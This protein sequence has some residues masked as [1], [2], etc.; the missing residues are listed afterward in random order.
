MQVIAP[1]KLLAL[2][3]FINIVL[4]IFAINMHGMPAVYALMLVQFF[5]SIMF[6]TIFSLSIA[7]TGNDAKLGSSLV[8]MAIVGGAIMPLIM[9]KISD[10][11]HSIQIAYV[12]PLLCFVVVCLFG[13][14]ASQIE[15]TQ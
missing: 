11:T 5:M 1:N 15:R 4:L 3:A 8:I 10:S 12:I 14:K 13:M 6:P 7:G 2:Y 9:G